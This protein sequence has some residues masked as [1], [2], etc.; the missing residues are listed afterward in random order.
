MHNPEAEE[1]FLSRTAR[2]E[3]GTALIESLKRLGEYELHGDL[4][5]CKAPYAVTAQ[6]VFCGAA[7]MVDTF[8]RLRPSDCA[9]ALATGA[10]PASIGPDWVRIALF[11]PHWPQ[12]DIAHWALKSYDFA[13]TGK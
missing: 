1:F 6:T 7:G 5:V 12:P 10:E 2:D 4:R 8:W 11:R 9:I 13:R 3:V